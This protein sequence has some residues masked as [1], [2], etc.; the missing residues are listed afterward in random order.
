MRITVF[1]NHHKLC[2]CFLC[3]LHHFTVLIF[4]FKPGNRSCKNYFKIIDFRI[5]ITFFNKKTSN[6][7]RK[8]NRTFFNHFNFRMK[9]SKN[10]IFCPPKICYFETWFNR[11]V[12]IMAISWARMLKISGNTLLYLR[13]KSSNFQLNRKPGKWSNIF[14]TTYYPVSN[15]KSTL[16]ISYSCP[17]WLSFVP[18]ISTCSSVKPLKFVLSWFSTKAAV[19]L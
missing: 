19:L 6:F 7:T 5:W 12:I 10:P 1:F 17:T 2:F 16:C 13:Q 11:L 18:M 4:G 14:Y 3:L 8:N 9:K 15:Q